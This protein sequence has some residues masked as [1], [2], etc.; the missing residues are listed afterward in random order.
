M[1]I[2]FLGSA[3]AEAVPA[4]WCVCDICRQARAN[5]GKDIRQRTSYLLN[6]DTLI[7]FGPD[8]FHQSI[9]CNIQWSEIKRLIITHAH[10]DHL[11]PNELLW[12][13]NGRFSKTQSEL[14]IF[15][16]SKVLKRIEIEIQRPFVKR[17]F[18][19]F[20]DFKIAATQVEPAKLIIDDD[21]QIFPI[22]ANHADSNGQEVNY[23][24]THR[25]KSILIA[26]DTG[27]WDECAWKQISNF[28]LDGAVIECT[29]G[30]NPKGI[31]HRLGHMGANVSVE[32]RDK[33]LELGVINKKT[34]VIVNHFSHN[35]WPIHESL[36]DF[37]NPR[38]IQVGY[39]GLVLDL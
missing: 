5:G 17:I 8:I 6:Q 22:K 25:D 18:A 16:T 30:I 38:G 1:K 29:M 2:V 27:W 32:F 26:N 28:R 15:G 9:L 11:E 34:P 13:L 35:G 19:S 7:D 3:A 33:L 24:L 37:F 39:D 12:R 21:L 20:E 36:C 4:I 10:E 23:V 31:D 14:K